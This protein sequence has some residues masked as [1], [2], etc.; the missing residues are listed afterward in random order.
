MFQCTDSVRN[1]FLLG[2][3]RQKLVLTSSI[4]SFLLVI[5]FYSKQPS[6]S[7]IATLQLHKGLLFTHFH[8]DKYSISPKIAAIFHDH[9]AKPHNHPYSSNNTSLGLWLRL[10]WLRHWRCEAQ[11]QANIRPLAM[12][13]PAFSGLCQIHHSLIKYTHQN[14]LWLPIILYKAS[15]MTAVWWGL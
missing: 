15:F 2:W 13:Q 8:I 1:I 6:F 11:S 5:S 4:A 3:L 12:W 7:L 9:K 14:T 10:F